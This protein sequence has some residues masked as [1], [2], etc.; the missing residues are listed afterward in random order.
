MRVLNFIK[1]LLGTAAALAVAGLAIF[2]VVMYLAKLSWDANP[3]R[4][5]IAAAAERI[6]P[7]PWVLSEGEREA[8]IDQL[9]GLIYTDPETGQLKILDM[10]DTTGWTVR[11]P[12]RR[13]TYS[14]SAL[15]QEPCWYYAVCY[16]DVA[17]VVVKAKAKDL[18]QGSAPVPPAKECEWSWE[19]VEESGYLPGW[20]ALNMAY[21]MLDNDLAVFNTTDYGMLYCN[22]G[23]LAMWE[24]YVHT[25]ATES[26]DFNLTENPSLLDNVIT[27]DATRSFPLG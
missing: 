22:S 13:Y 4:V 26:S 5:Q 25:D 8:I 10:S 6:S 27:S 20:T 14:G 19:I 3:L 9:W 17:Y 21:T 7:D 24:N 1:R 15:V 12:L 16:D 18:P 2:C 23:C 11:E